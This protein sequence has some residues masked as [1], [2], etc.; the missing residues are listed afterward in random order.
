VAVFHY[1]G[2]QHCCNIIFSQNTFTGETSLR[3]GESDSK[4]IDEIEEN[5]MNYV[6]LLIRMKH[7]NV[8]THAPSDT[9]KKFTILFEGESTY[10]L[11][12]TSKFKLNTTHN[13]AC[14]S[15]RAV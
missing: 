1:S 8:K 13:F 15:G 11:F 14:P 7:Y 5:S 4:G 3:E 10:K 6:F 9:N 2:I 12:L